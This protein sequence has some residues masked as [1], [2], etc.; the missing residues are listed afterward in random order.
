MPRPCKRRRVCALPRESRFAP[1]GAEGRMLPSVLM[2]VEE[3]ECVRL[4]DHEGLTQEQ[5]A[6]RMAVARTTVQAIYASARAKLA[7][8]LFTESE[9]LVGGGEYVLCD[10]AARCGGCPRRRENEQPTIRRN[11]FMKIAVTYENGQVFQHFGHTQ[12]FKV[13]EVK[14]GKMSSALV[15][16]T[17]GGHSALAGMLADLGVDTLI[18]GGI[19]MG[20]Q[21]ALDNADI[22]LYAGI[23]G[24][25][26]EAVAKLLAGVLPQNAQAN[27]DHHGHEHGHDCHGHDHDHDCGHDHGHDC[28]CRH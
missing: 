23:T 8:F 3:Y 12:C 14:D 16:V 25:A 7:R 18:C 15:P 10:G 11:R 26:D 28:G 5:C 9:L 1:R 13:F 19:G 17:G 22:Q 2:T 4:I 20:A 6:A 21:V 24:S 27:C